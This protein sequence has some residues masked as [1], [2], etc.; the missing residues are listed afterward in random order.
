[1]A[2]E[3]L[4]RTVCDFT[5]PKQFVHLLFHFTACHFFTGMIFSQE[6]IRPGR[7]L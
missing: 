2:G 4:G 1:M 3:W 6:E 7:S 5:S